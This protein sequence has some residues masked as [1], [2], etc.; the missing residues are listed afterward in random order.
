MKMNYEMT[1]YYKI[2]A[3]F[4]EKKETNLCYYLIII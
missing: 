4:V 1:A 2:N 3:I